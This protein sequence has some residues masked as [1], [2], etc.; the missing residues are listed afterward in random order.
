MIVNPRVHIV[1]V[2]D[3]GRD[4]TADIIEGEARRVAAMRAVAARHPST[5]FVPPA[6]PAVEAEPECGTSPAA[7]GE[8]PAPVVVAGLTAVAATW[9]RFARR[10]I[11]VRGT[12]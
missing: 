8:S 3:G 10:W 11:G 12:P 9:S 2:A 7:L 5:T 4:Y 1:V 6:P